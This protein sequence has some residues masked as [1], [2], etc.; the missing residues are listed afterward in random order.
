M[1]IITIKGF[2]GVDCKAHAKREF[3]MNA[4]FAKAMR[5]MERVV[6]TLCACGSRE[7]HNFHAAFSLAR[8]TSRR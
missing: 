6:F 4:L 7:A 8:Q 1:G 2:T 5:R 3:P